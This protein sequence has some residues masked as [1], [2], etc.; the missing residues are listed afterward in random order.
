MTRAPALPLRPIL[1]LKIRSRK[2]EAKV[3]VR[4]ECPLGCEMD[5]RE[6]REF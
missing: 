1:S 4:A 5:R 3:G 2:T 6:R